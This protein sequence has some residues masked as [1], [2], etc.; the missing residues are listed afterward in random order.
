MHRTVGFAPLDQEKDKM[1]DL[2]GTTLHRLG[3]QLP[4]VFQCPAAGHDVQPPTI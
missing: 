3:E 1:K 2:I 4:G